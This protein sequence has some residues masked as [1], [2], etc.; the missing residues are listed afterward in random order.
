MFGSH[1]VPGTVVPVSL[2]V[3]GSTCIMG[4]DEDS[5]VQFPVESYET[6]ELSDV[7]KITRKS[8]GEQ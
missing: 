4:T 5:E 7:T 1:A 8:V 2:V 6:G 3:H